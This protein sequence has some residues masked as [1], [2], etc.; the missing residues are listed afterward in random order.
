LTVVTHMA[1]GAAAGSFLDSQVG[2]ALLGAASHVALDAMPHYE[3]EKLWVELAAVVAVFG[4]LL[5]AGMGG[6]GLF[7]GALGA[8]LPDA[9]NM[10]WRL[11][12]IPG[13]LKI[14]PG[15]SE[16]L[17]GVL[18][19]G[20][21]LPRRHGLTQIALIAVCVTLAVLRVRSSAA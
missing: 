21:S 18:P 6:T 3:F 17:S 5:L 15:H 10:A 14:F 4:G 7:W 1:V 19:H 20:R 8:A 9:E 16:R 2:A 12:L 11:G 13:R